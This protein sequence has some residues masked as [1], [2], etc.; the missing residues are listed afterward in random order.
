MTLVVVLDVNTLV[1]A[2]VSPNGLP[3]SLVTEGF[4]GRYT[5]VASDH[6]VRKLD[7][8]LKRPY[9]AARLS[10]QQRVEV[11]DRTRV[12]ANIVIPDSEISGICDDEEDDIVLGTAVA[13]GA[14]YVVTGD[15]GFLRVGRYGSVQIVTARE[16]LA[17]LDAG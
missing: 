2:A 10:R 1:S 13:A 12:S 15:H 11:V 6:V 14:D 16:F 7:E 3:A 5:I 8:V 4:K 17:I 9:F